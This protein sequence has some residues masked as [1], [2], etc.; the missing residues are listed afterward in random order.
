MSLSKLPRALRWN[1]FDKLCNQTPPCDGY[2]ITRKFIFRRSL[3]AGFYLAA[4]DSDDDKNKFEYIYRKYYR[5]MLHTAAGIIKNPTLAEDAVHETFV[6]LLRGIDT[7]RIDNERALK[8]YLYMVTRER[9]ID[10]LRKWERRRGAQPDYESLAA[11]LDNYAEPEEVALT[12]L[13]LDK[14]I[15][16]L[17]EMP[18]IYRQTLVLR[19]KGYSIREIAK[20]TDSSESNVKTRI[21]RARAMLLKSFGEQAE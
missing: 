1:K 13:Q 11:A 7:L 17:D 19:V 21:H 6:Q 8:S 12:N 10:F 2:L 20:I 5:F 3:R 9:S 14:A 4:L 16:L 18:L 15:A